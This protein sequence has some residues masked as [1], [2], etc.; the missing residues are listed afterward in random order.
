[1]NTRRHPLAWAG[2]YKKYP[3]VTLREKILRL[4]L[5]KGPMNINEIAVTLNTLRQSVYEKLLIARRE[6]HVADQ[7]SQKP[8]R[9]GAW[10]IQ[11][12]FAITDGG[13]EWL[14]QQERKF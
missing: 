11:H 2:F 3:E 12:L 7:W 5:E 13:K 9:I 1:M 6:G 10:V 4:L 14:K 8:N